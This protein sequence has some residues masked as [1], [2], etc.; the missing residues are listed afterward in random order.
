MWSDTAA[1]AT[2][3]DT[4]TPESRSASIATIWQTSAAFMSMIPCP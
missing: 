2:V 1:I 3:P 4:G